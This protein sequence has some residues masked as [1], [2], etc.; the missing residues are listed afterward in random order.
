MINRLSFD[1]FVGRMINKRIMIRN[2]KRK[3]APF[4]LRLYNPNEIEEALGNVGLE[5]DKIFGNFDSAPLGSNSNSM[6]IV[7]KKRKLL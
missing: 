3:D 6:I 7:A 5:I 4:T 2:G 1:S